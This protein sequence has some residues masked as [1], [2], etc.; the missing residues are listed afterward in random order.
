M[1]EGNEKREALLKKQTHVNSIPSRLVMLKSRAQENIHLAE[2]VR[3][4]MIEKR[5][6]S[7]LHRLEENKKFNEEEGYH[8]GLRT[9]CRPTEPMRVTERLSRISIRKAT[10]ARSP[11][12]ARLL[13]TA[14][15]QLWIRFV[16][17]FT[18]L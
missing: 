10:T 9:P 12:I 17:C 14:Q 18:V 16:V 8:L 2:M 7:L 1:N 3:T 11:A 4:K 5:R 15:D 6:N 13:P